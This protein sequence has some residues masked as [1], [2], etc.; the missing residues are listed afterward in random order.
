[1]IEQL[2]N[3]AI[4]AHVDHGKT[5]LVDKLL[6]LSGTLDRKE[7]ENERV[8]DSNDQ[9]KE[10]GITI[11]AKNTALK[12]KDYSINIVDTPG[13]ADFG[14]EVERV[15]SMVDSVLLVVDAQ[16][17]PMPQTRFVTQ[18]AFKAGL[19]PIVVV[20]KI[21]R[22]GARPDWVIDQIFDLFDNLG[23]TDEQLDF[24]IVYASAL[25]GIA[26]MDHEAMDDNMD[27]LFQAIIDHVPA[28]K[29]DTTGPFQM[30]ISQLDYNSFLGVIGIGRIARGTIKANS[31]VTA[32]GA[33]GKKR[34]GRILK[35]MGHSG[36][37][38]VEVQEATAGDIVCVSGM[39]ELYISDT[40]CDQNNVEALPPLTVDQPTVS[41]TFQVNDSPFAGKEGKFVTSRN[42]KDRLDKE[43]LHNVA[44][45]VEQGESPEKF[46]VSGRGELHLSVLIENMRREGFELAVGRPEVVI[47]EVDGEKQEPYE[48][49]TIDIEEQH[50]GP[51]ME[52]MGLRKGDLTNMIPDGKGRIRL[53]YTIPARGLIG[54]RN[55]FLTLTS[56]SGILTSTFSHYGA[57]K[58]G[59]VSN[60]QNGVLVSMATGTAL[61]YSLETLQARGKL[62]LSP[63]DEIYEGQLCGINSRDNDLVLNP[64]KGKKL[65]NMR[66]SGKDEVIALVPPI[67]FTLEQA[68]EFIADDEL[69]EVTPKS[70]R[71]R[72]KYLNENDR[73]RFER[74]KV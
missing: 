16:D 44:L 70:I 3:I 2:R 34:N 40:L 14:G 69:V 39:D 54:F 53:E 6:R 37:Q 68:L 66:A 17:G 73:K 11:L 67:K 62:F 23:A 15:M 5:T 33:D 8:M 19:R 55:N 71:L 41:M 35:I 29:V 50:Q 12:W 49:V 38:R 7:L 48:N 74:S 32:I 31:P 64:T 4:I 36:L 22:P 21:D 61:T 28:P 20:N 51:V 47:I 60:R 58:A 59:E 63:G 26:G 57:I 45:R 46:K 56:G 24:P 13:H 72:K 27:A 18:K 25:N 65:D 1:M 52:Q 9:E 43:L 30:Q 42:I 10:R